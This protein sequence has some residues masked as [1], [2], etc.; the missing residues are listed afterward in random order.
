[1]L[2]SASTAAAKVI[3]TSC[4][5]K[6]SPDAPDVRRHIRERSGCQA[7]PERN[8]RTFQFGREQTVSFIETKEN[9]GVNGLFSALTLYRP[10]LFILG[11]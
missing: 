10:L 4:I 6:T 1:M 11:G 9:T 8:Q 7:Q 2:D 3:S 5:D